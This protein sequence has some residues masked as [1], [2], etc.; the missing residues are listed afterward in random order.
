MSSTSST[1]PTNTIINDDKILSSSLL[2]SKTNTTFDNLTNVNLNIN[3]ESL[4]TGCLILKNNSNV[5]PVI[6]SSLS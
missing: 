5:A 1:T 6:S 3:N 4:S 2:V